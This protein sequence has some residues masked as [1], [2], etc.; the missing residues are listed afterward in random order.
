[1]FSDDDSKFLKAYMSTIKEQTVHEMVEMD[2]RTDEEK[3]KDQII[4]D[5]LREVKRAMYGKDLEDIKRIRARIK[6]D[7]LL[8]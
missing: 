8:Y 2:Y 3:I 1:M 4:E 6:Q 5:T 7:L